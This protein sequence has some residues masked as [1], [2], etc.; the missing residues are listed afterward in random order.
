MSL[1]NQPQSREIKSN[2]QYFAITSLTFLNG[3]C[4]VAKKML[5]F[6][7]SFHDW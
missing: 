1:K 6:I 7:H 3:A 2:I 5:C 4:T